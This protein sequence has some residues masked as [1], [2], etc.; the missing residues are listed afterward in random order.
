MTYQVSFGLIIDDVTR[1]H[2]NAS[3]EDGYYGYDTIRY[4]RRKWGPVPLLLMILRFMILTMEF[5]DTLYRRCSGFGVN[6]LHDLT[7]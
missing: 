7:I 6:L 4:L 5:Y 1:P 2:M 3:Q